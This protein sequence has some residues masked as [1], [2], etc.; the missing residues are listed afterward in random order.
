M[1]KAGTVTMS[2]QEL[3]Q[4]LKDTVR[5][6]MAQVQGAA[7]K[8][9]RKPQKHNLSDQG[10]V[11]KSNAAKKV[12]KFFKNGD[13]NQ[14]MSYNQRRR[15]MA[16]S[17]AHWDELDGLSTAQAAVASHWLEKGDIVTINDLTI[18]PR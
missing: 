1:S 12:A 17:N 11:A 16:L 14:P 2:K 6:A 4:L 13:A 8:A 15:L 7:P 10:T 9:S 18:N 3:D 5:Q